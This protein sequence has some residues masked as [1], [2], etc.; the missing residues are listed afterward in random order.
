MG[1]PYSM[2][3][4][5][6]RANR[7]IESGK[8]LQ[9]ESVFQEVCSRWPNNV[10]ALTG[11]ARVA[12][13]QMHWADALVRWRQLADVMPDNPQAWIGQ[14]NA[15]IALGELA[16]ADAVFQEACSRW[17]DNV[18]VLTGCAR[19]AVL[20][21]RWTDALDRWRQ[22][23]DVMPDN[24][25]A[26]I[27]QGNALIELGKLAKADAVFQEACSRWPD[28]VPVLTGCARAAVLQKHWTEA[29]DRWQRMAVVAPDNPQPWIGQGN[30]LI[31]L[32]E[33]ER[34]EAVFQ[35]ACTHWPDNVHALAGYART[36]ALLKRRADALQR[37]RRMATVAPGNPQS[38]IGQGNVLIKMGEFDQ[39]VSVFE[40]ARL[41]WPDNAH[42][43]SG[44]AQAVELRQHWAGTLEFWRRLEKADELIESGELDSAERLCLSSQ[45][46]CPNLL[47]AFSLH[48]IILERRRRMRDRQ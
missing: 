40:E 24:P 38:W 31:G 46:E 42:V 47:K 21:K 48:H 13:L 29:L 41:R 27:G 10:H 32:A 14:G 25:Q 9:A 20:Q 23:A 12:V 43:L 44:Y 37:W 30:A 34:A 16:K 28:N 18:P 45:A 26:W 19:A 17:P 15:L 11:Y 2:D 39:A 5:V 35:E 3:D 1:V 33:F 6:D 36:A 4:L 7:L 8:L 22:L